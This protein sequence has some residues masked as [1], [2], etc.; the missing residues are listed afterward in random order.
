MAAF[1]DEVTLEEIYTEVNEMV[2]V[3]FP[4]DA[5]TR[6]FKV[7][8]QTLYGANE[9]VKV[10]IAIPGENGEVEYIIAEGV[11]DGKGSV[12]FTLSEANYQKVAG[13]TVVVVP[14][15]EKK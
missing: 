11:A 12:F 8:F 7:G 9:T 14:V 5:K 2:T 10:V 1:G 4:A 6:T 3:K 15:S 13:K